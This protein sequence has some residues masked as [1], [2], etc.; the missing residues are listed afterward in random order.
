MRNIEELKQNPR[1]RGKLVSV[2]FITLENSV[3]ILTQY[4]KDYYG[5]IQVISS[6]QT[7]NESLILFETRKYAIDA[8]T[9][10]CTKSMIDG[11]TLLKTGL[12]IPTKEPLAPPAP[13]TPIIKKEPI[14]KKESETIIPPD[15][16]NHIDMLPPLLEPP[17]VVAPTKT[18]KRKRTPNELK[19]PSVLVVK[20][21][22]AQKKRKLNE[23]KESDQLFAYYDK[24]IEKQRYQSPPPTYT[25]QQQQQNQKHQQ[26]TNTISTMGMIPSNYYYYY[27]PTTTTTTTYATLPIM[28]RQPPP[29]PPP[30]TH[31][32]YTKKTLW[33]C[34]LAPRTTASELHSYIL[35][36]NISG[37]IKSR[38]IQP[39]IFNGYLFAYVL[40]A[41]ESHAN[42]AL[43]V[44]KNS[45]YK[46]RNL[47]VKYSR[48]EFV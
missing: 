36:S 1:T 47:V 34:N 38:I 45:F 27:H 26:Q 11:G 31:T 19:T 4:F 14:V 13:P 40:F 22:P 37:Y 17:K 48:T 2:E 42:V 23:K 6:T 43:S 8:A 46:G 28:P 15:L 39:R 24:M 21:E 33:I 10:L 32:N 25:T 16:F 5:F 18:K 20:E 12:V 29:P 7:N 35:S 9:K 30:P 3:N 44:L 41:S